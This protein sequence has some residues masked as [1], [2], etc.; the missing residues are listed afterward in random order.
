MSAVTLPVDHRRP[1]A[2]PKLRNQEDLCFV[3]FESG[4][5]AG[6]LVIHC[7]VL[8]SQVTRSLPDRDRPVIGQHAALGVLARERQGRKVIIKTLSVSAGYF[9]GVTAP[10][11]PA[12]CS[13][14]RPEQARQVTALGEG[15]LAV[16][17]AA[18]AW[19]WSVL[20]G[21]MVTT[22]AIAR[23]AVPRSEATTADAIRRPGSGGNLPLRA[24]LCG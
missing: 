14:P 13:G 11:A 3:R 5:D 18:G 2:K 16:V 24:C 17:S 7:Q 6:T 20:A 8:T 4:N 10:P 22:D 21:L 1:A 12:P 15:W 19:R 9:G 23:P